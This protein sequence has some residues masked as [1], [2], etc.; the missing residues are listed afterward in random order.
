MPGHLGWEGG[1]A[2]D[3][4]VGERLAAGEVVGGPAEGLRG[5]G[6]DD[7]GHLDEGMRA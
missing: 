1:A 6:L 3:I 5:V 2:D 4:D 7:A